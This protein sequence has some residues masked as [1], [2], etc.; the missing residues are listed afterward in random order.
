MIK[1]GEN[2]AS[3]FFYL[4]YFILICVKVIVQNFN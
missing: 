1:N 2:T 4:F 3:F